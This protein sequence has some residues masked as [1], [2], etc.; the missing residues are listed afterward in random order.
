MEALNR[1]GQYRYLRYPIHQK[2]THH[3]SMNKRAQS[4]SHLDQFRC[5]YRSSQLPSNVTVDWLG[6][7]T[8]AEIRIGACSFLHTGSISRR[9][10]RGKST[11]LVLRE[12]HGNLVQ[13]IPRGSYLP[14]A[15]DCNILDGI[16]TRPSRTDDLI[17]A[18]LQQ[19][20]GST[21]K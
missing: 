19:L 9:Q 13:L 20:S 18:F 1:F 7:A 3:L 11:G 12:H 21:V 5:P 17:L 10:E 4:R 8:L 15:I 16:R 6:A 14:F 2:E